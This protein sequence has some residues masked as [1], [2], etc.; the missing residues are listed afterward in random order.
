[1]IL[2][3]YIYIILDIKVEKKD[4]YR[5]N[6]MRSIIILILGEKLRRFLAIHP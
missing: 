1:M 4:V 5:S 2:M 3:I 6:Q